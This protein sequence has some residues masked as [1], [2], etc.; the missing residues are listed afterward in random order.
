MPPCPAPYWLNGWQQT[1]FTIDTDEDYRALEQPQARMVYDAL[2]PLSEC[3]PV[4][5]NKDTFPMLT[6]F[7][8]VTIGERR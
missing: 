1:V 5:V 7:D 3:A 6:G 2:T 8:A 4:F